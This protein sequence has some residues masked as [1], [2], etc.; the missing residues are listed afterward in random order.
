MSITTNSMYNNT[1]Y[2][3]YI[4]TICTNAKTMVTKKGVKR[5]ICEASPRILGVQISF[6]IFFL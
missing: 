1:F 5:L 3:I 6:G 2:L 4:I